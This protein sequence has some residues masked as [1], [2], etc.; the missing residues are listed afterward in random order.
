MK[1]RT[2]ESMSSSTLTYLYGVVPLDTPEPPETLRGVDGHAVRLLRGGGV[3]GAVSEVPTDLYAEDPLNARLTDLAWV[4]E[5]GVAHERVLTWFADRGTVIPLAPF[6][7]HHDEARV[8]ERLEEDSAR[9]QKVLARLAGRQEWSIKVWRIESAISEHLDELSPRVRALTDEM[10][11]AS[12]GRRFLLTKKRDAARVEEL[13]TVSG[14][15]A[16][17]VFEELRERA[18]ASQVLPIP[19]PVE[20][21]ER[22][23]AL[24][25]AFLVPET[26]FSPFQQSVSALAAR[27]RRTGFDWE[28]TGPW[29]PYHFA[30]A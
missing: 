12:P 3:M 26:E 20:G 28:F 6:S 11:K 27:Y 14:E 4:G 7:L 9:Y 5:R 1:I 21:S 18:E 24:H 8:R 19:A 30:S 25:A 16:R 2:R 22:T 13:R 23:L 15:V 17:Q 29:P 10:Q